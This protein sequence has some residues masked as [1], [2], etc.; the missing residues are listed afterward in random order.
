MTCDGSTHDLRVHLEPAAQL[1]ERPTSLV[2][3]GGFLGLHRVQTRAANGNAAACEMGCRRQAVDMELLGQPA[4]GRA[5][6]VG[7]DQLV[8]FGCLSE[9]FEPSHVSGQTGPG[10]PQHRVPAI[11]S[12]SGKPLATRETTRFVR[13]AKV[14]KLST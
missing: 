14:V 8:D 1:H 13:R 11:A 4:Q 7:S 12:M 2:Q 9:K 5:G 3:L 6:L 10:S